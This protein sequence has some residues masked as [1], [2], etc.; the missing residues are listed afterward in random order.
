MDMTDDFDIEE[1]I[2]EVMAVL[3]KMASDGEAM[4]E[5]VDGLDQL[6]LDDDAPLRLDDAMYLPEL[7]GYFA[8]EPNFRSKSD[9]FSVK[10]LRAA[11]KRG[12]LQVLRPDAKNHYV[13]RRM[14]R[15]W[16]ERC[17]D[18]GKS[19][20]SSSAARATRTG[21]SPTMQP[22][23]SRTETTLQLA[24]AAAKAS[25]TKPS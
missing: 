3:D 11:I 4:Q 1:S 7:G 25:M 12:D 16:L 23:A 20:T 9:A 15:E 21:G 8:R 14:I 6:P 18:E 2:G 10:T 19:H 22:G 24:L 17:H 13:T 5:I